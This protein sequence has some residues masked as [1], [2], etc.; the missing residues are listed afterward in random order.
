MGKRLLEKPRYFTLN[1]GMQVVIQNMPGKNS[2]Q[3]ELFVKIGLANEKLKSHWGY[4]HFIEHMCFKGT[5]RRNQKKLNVEA[6]AIGGEFNAYTDREYT[7][8]QIASHS[9]HYH[10]ALDIISD[11][12]YNS[13]F[14]NEEFNKEKGPIKEEVKMRYDSYDIRMYDLFSYYFFPDNH[15]QSLIGSEEHISNIKRDSLYKFYKENYFPSNTILTISG[16]TKKIKESDIRTYF[17]D[18]SEPRD[19]LYHNNHFRLNKKKLIVDQDNSEQGKFYIVLP[20]MKYTDENIHSLLLFDDLMTNGMSSRLFQLLRED[21]GLCY[22]VYSMDAS[23]RDSGYWVVGGAC[24]NDNLEKCIN[25][26]I[27]EI[28]ETINGKLTKKEF[29][30]VKNKFITSLE[31]A[32][33]SANHA[34]KFNFKSLFYRGHLVDYYYLVNKMRDL[35]YQDCLQHVNDLWGEIDVP[36]VQLLGNFPKKYSIKVSKLH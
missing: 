19:I 5:K 1:N 27:K 22:S 31:L 8:F 6:D 18:S 33:E 3:I 16:D 28:K 7:C 9:K 23:L 30:S 2:I 12:F 10:Q 36:H 4:T 14:D 34:N 13:I 20:G 29:D 26:S 11:I 25:T 35:K 17:E 21:K 15:G 32:L 24:S